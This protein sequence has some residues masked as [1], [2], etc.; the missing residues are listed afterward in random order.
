MALTRKRELNEKQLAAI[1]SNQKLTHG[2]AT[3]ET[4]DRIRAAH[5]RH[6]F[7]ESAEAVALQSLGEEPREISGFAGGSLGHLQ[8]KRR[9]A[10]GDGDPAGSGHL[11][12]ESH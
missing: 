1:R 3:A 2:P 4:R 8:P 12:N 6:G 5:L 10:G 9:G 11:A 7:C